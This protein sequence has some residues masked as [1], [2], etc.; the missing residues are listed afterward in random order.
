[1]AY[2]LFGGS[3]ADFAVTTTTVPASAGGTAAA[4]VLAGGVSL[5]AWDA[6]AA[7]TQITD[8]KLFT[9]SYTAEGGTAPSGVFPSQADGT[10]LV[11][12]QDTVTELHVTQSGSASQRWLLSPVGLTSRVKTMETA[13]Y[14]P[15]AQKGV[16]SGV[17]S[18]DVTGKVPAA[19][20]PGASVSGV[21]DITTPVGGTESG[22]VVLS[23]ADL[24]AVPTTRTISVGPG[25]TG[26]GALSANVTVTPVFGNTAGTIA[27]GND[28]RFGTTGTSPRPVYAVVLSNDAPADR[29]AA[30]ASDAY[31]WVCD[32][33]N[34]EVQINLAIDAASPK[35]SYNAGMPA[36]AASLGKVEM[37]GGR[38]N[39]GSAGIKMRTAVHLEG[40]GIG[41]TELRAVAC[42]Q[43]GLINLAN[44]NDH[45]CELSN[46]YMNGNSASGGTC[47]AIKF[48]MTA[49]GNTSLYPDT[50][51]DAD[52]HIHDLFIDEFRG[53]NRHGI[54]LY[55]DTSVVSSNNRGNIIDRV[56][57]RDCTGGNGIF[58]DAASDCFIANCH[59]G[60]SGLSGYRIA[61]GNTKMSN[62]KSFYSNQYGVYVTSGRI[63]IT[64]HEAQDD[65]TGLFLDGVPGTAT[66]LVVDTC[67]QAGI[68]LSNDRVQVVGF[69]I[70]VRGGGRYT[71]QARGL[72]YDAALNYCCVI[73]NVENA[74]M[75]TPIS[76]TTPANSTI[77]VTVS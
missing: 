60:G 70:F 37:S 45:L 36:S 42:N 62:N 23:A 9:G 1:M 24:G 61:G 47:S 6:G 8:L 54:W 21:T 76:G 31:T 10:I 27:Q 51:P 74:N 44:V 57:V 53:T 43:P 69:N 68:R 35:Q 52:H 4:L 77:L 72:W 38:F 48:D 5:E 65:D 41:S 29:K 7:G 46:F 30:A 66:S 64:G 75:T 39:I 50:N 22:N 11:W 71:T 25:M 20:L 58:L 16:A 33:T 32:G 55:A 3:P 15:T 18:L 19:Q 73:G 49:S 34:D 28:P 40:A 56:Q 12:A 63:N 13:N 2:I 26:G 67:N 17:A 14:I 59:V